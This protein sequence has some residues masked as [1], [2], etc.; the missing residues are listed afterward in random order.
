VAGAGA[1]D[2]SLVTEQGFVTREAWFTYDNA[3]DSWSDGEAVSAAV[4][5]YE[6]P[7]EVGGL[8]VDGFYDTLYWCGG[9]MGY[10]SSIAFAGLSSQRGLAGELQEV[11]PLSSLPPLGEVKVWAPGEPRPLPYPVSYG[12]H[13]DND[14]VQITTPR[15]LDWDLTFIEERFAAV[16]ALYSWADNID[17]WSGPEVTLYGDDV[18]LL[19]DASGVAGIGDAADELLLEEGAADAV[20]M[21]LGFSW[22]E[23]YEDGFTDA[24]SVVTGVSD[25]QPFE[26]GVVAG[27]SGV[28]MRYSPFSG[29]FFGESIRAYEG[30]SNLVPDR[31]GREVRYQVSR[32]RL[33]ERTELGEIAGY[34][35]LTVTEPVDLLG[36][37]VGIDRSADLVV[38][39]DP[40]TVGEDPS[41]IGVELRI[42][43]ARTP[44]ADGPLEL[45]RITVRGEPDV[46]EVVIPAQ[47]LTSLPVVTNNFDVNYDQ[48]E[49]WAELTVASHQLRKVPLE[50]G[51]NLVVDW[52]HVVNAP[53]RIP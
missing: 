30:L 14:V 8:T 48:T 7:I 12:A 24:V 19:L 47:V 35:E 23:S 53:V 25:V 50:G 18:C 20:S 41:V 1:V 16:E 10:A 28:V 49:L 44:S 38:R 37:R 9:E 3:E 45:W 32:E 13:G 36:G 29:Y 40:L 2:V 31:D 34:Q 4:M 6:C 26:D 17:A 15:D 11:V 46:G 33:G 5:R 22:T 42:V 51:G 21:T 43:D 27:S 52:M 39:W